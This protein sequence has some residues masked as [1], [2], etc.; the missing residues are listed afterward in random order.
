MSMMI[1]VVLGA[2]VRRPAKWAAPVAS[3][4]GAGV[5]GFL[6]MGILPLALFAGGLATENGTWGA[7]AGHFGVWNDGRT[8]Y[9]GALFHADLEARVT[10]AP[11]V[12][13][14]LQGILRSIDLL[15]NQAKVAIF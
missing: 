8:R 2:F 4:F 10:I 12:E 11:R 7:G 5:T 6:L 1:G 9:L 14:E 13:Q 15:R 3:M